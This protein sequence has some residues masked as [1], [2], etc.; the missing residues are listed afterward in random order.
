M[1]PGSLEAEHEQFS[2]HYLR[3]CANNV[4]KNHI[5][6]IKDNIYLEYGKQLYKKLFKK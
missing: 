6:I 2:I 3:L 4:V 1:I 5:Q